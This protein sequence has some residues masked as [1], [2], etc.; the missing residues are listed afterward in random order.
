VLQQ[1]KNQSTVTAKLPNYNVAA[2]KKVFFFTLREN[3]SASNHHQ[4]N[5]LSQP[6][7]LSFDG[8][9]STYP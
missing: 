7:N 2:N 3:F 5:V 9:L 1:T 8:L 4:Q 6:Y